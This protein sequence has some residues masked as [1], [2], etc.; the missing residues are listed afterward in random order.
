MFA[1]LLP[2]VVVKLAQGKGAQVAS[3]QASAPQIIRRAG[4]GEAALASVHESRAH[5]LVLGDVARLPR[6]TKCSHSYCQKS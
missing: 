6:S 3:A 1:I 4:L 5:F 2:E